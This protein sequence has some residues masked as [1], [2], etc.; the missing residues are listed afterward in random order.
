VERGQ[1]RRISILPL[2][3]SH[4]VMAF[5]ESPFDQVSAHFS[6]DGRWVA[7]A[8]NESGAFEV[9]VQSF[10]E[11]GRKHQ[12]STSGGFQPRWRR[13][14]KELYYLAPDRRLMSVAVGRGETVQL[15]SPQPL[16]ELP[17]SNPAFGFAQRS[18]DVTS[19]GQRFIVSRLVPQP[20]ESIT[21]VINWTAGL[22]R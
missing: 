8:S 15:G 21:V 10:P 5:G 22:K 13:D 3:G 11:R 19:D 9:Y 18:Y 6:P 14:G 7:Y 2:E 16:F 1:N 12:V 4:D 20:P 17:V